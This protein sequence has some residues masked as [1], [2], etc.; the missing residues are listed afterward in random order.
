MDESSSFWT[1]NQDREDRCLLCQYV[2]QRKDKISVFRDDGWSKVQEAAENWSKINVD[3]DDIKY[4]FT[5]VHEKI[6]G[7][8]HAFGRV[9]ISCR[10]SFRTKVGKFENKYGLIPLREE[11][12]HA[13]SSESVEG[14]SRRSVS[15]HLT[16]KI[17][18]FICNVKRKSDNNP[19]E[20]GGLGRCEKDR[21][22]TR[23]LQ[24]K[25]EYIQDSEHRFFS[26]AN[27]LQLAISGKSHD[28]FAIDIYYHQSCYLKFAVNEQG[29]Q[30]RID[31]DLDDLKTDIMNE[32]L[33]KIRMKILREKQAFFT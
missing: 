1:L 20:A 19:Y 15:Q 13:D 12:I 4:T 10:T 14:V 2:F 23:L 11:D 18:C 28:I 29:R 17:L 8:D 22:A 21:S 6:K 32:V 30:K 33:A 5:K 7:S 3:K 26:A 9:H 31:E 24:R 27:R 25:E 16:E